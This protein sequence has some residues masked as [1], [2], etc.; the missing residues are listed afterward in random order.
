ME[1]G[2][3]AS[4]GTAYHPVAETGIG[5]PARA[6]R[7]HPGG[8]ADGQA[9]RVGI[10]EE[11]HAAVEEVAV[12]IN[13]PRRDVLAGDVHHLRG[14]HREVRPQ[15]GDPPIGEGHVHAPLEAGA[16]IEDGAAL[17]QQIGVDQALPDFRDEARVAVHQR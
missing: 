6:A 9:G 7:I 13:E 17:E 10:H 4:V 5:G 3:H 1:E 16:G 8:H 12:E 2:E 14:A 15:R 11:R